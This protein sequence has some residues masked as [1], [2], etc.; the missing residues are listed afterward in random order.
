M[1]IAVD[2]HSHSGHAGGVG[3]ISLEGIAATMRKKG[4][5]VFGTGDCL[6]PEWL[7]FLE[8]NLTQKESGLFAIASAPHERFLLQTEIIITAPAPSGGRKTIHTIIL[9]PSFKAAKK[10]H[11]LLKKWGVKVN[12]GRPFLKCESSGEVA[13]KMAAL[14]KI[15][16]GIIIIPAHVMTPQG[17]FGS[18]R[19]INKLADVFAEFAEEIKVVETG[20]SADPQILALIPELDNRTLISNS[21]GHSAALNRV[22]REYTV[23]E[24]DRFD[25][26]SIHEALVNRKVAYTAEFSPAEGRFFL[27]GHR[28]GK[29]GHENGEHCY[30]SPENAPQVCPICSK[31]LTVGV[32]QRALELSIVQGDK[33]TLDTVT[34]KQEYFS[35]VPLTEVIAAGRGVKNPSS[36]KVLKDF[37]AIIEVV[38]TETALWLM[39][40]KDIEK[41]IKDVVESNVLAAVI[42]VKNENFSFAP[43]GYDGEY[44]QLV[45]DQQ[46]D[47]FGHC[48]VEGGNATL[49]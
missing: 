20:L 42:A 28:A 6:Q 32:L 9:F 47:W 41:E 18:E 36:P 8:K 34:P 14:Y 25:Y 23:L 17:V 2:L 16:H 3:N 44:G 40:E 37:E 13:E 21:D 7:E 31:P 39:S 15:E 30:F 19:P 10:S 27:T 1:Q 24:A 49:F 5:Q 33:R 38:G 22:G 29:K 35:M 4:I 43:L 45:L 48:H 26:P 12:I 11:K 46:V